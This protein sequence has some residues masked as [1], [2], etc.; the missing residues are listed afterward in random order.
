MHCRYNKLA[1]ICLL[2]AVSIP[3][4]IGVAAMISGSLIG[5]PLAALPIFVALST[6]GRYAV[7]CGDFIV[8]KT[9]FI[10]R[11]RAPIASILVIDG[12]SDLFGIN[13]IE[14]LD[15]VSKIR[16]GYMII[17]IFNVKYINSIRYCK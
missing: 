5:I 13:S 12:S 11:W 17:S 2:V 4:F 10:E 7:V 3:L 1:A 14:L 16:R 8:F 15:M 6:F 9:Y